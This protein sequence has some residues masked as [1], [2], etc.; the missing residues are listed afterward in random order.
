MF[1]HTKKVGSA[2][3]YGTRIGW[4]TRKQ[5]VRM[6]QESQKSKKCPSCGKT[7]IKRSSAGIW[8]CLSC[9]NTFAGGTFI[10]VPK[11]KKVTAEGEQTK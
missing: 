9:N 1:S 4:K 5:V 10:A 7:N 6:E 8:A 11:R 3:R 2:G